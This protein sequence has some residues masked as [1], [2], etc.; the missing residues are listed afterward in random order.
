[1]SSIAGT[2]A[3]THTHTHTHPPTHTPHHTHT[4]HTT[5]HT[6]TPHTQTQTHTP[7]THIRGRDSSVGIATRYGLEGPGIE[8]RWRQNIPRLSRPAL[9]SIQPPTQWL[10]GLFP[11]GTAAGAWR[12][13]PSPSSAGI[14]ESVEVYLCFSSGFSW[15]VLW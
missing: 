1:M 2:R 3:R 10:P 8:S 11:R 12:L 13:P 15:L 6:H 5:P 4:P 9:G 14:K 7:R